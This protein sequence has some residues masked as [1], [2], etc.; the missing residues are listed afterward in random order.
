MDVAVNTAKRWMWL[1]IRQQID[2]YN[3]EYGRKALD[4][5]VNEVEMAANL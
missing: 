2:G 4:V 3:R 1:R 5:A